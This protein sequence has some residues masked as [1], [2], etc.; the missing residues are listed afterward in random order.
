[1]KSLIALVVTAIVLALSATAL[2]DPSRLRMGVTA[3]T[4]PSTRSPWGI[5]ADGLRNRWERQLR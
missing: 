5:A 3:T 4:Q 1:M 2:A